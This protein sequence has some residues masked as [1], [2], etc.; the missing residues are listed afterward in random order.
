MLLSNECYSLIGVTSTNTCF[1]TQVYVCIDEVAVTDM[2]LLLLIF[3]NGIQIDNTWLPT[4]TFA[5]RQLYFLAH[6]SYHLHTSK[7]DV[8]ATTQNGIQINKAIID[9]MNYS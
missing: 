6:L 8:V 4:T 3:Y 9:S 7:D 2:L 5:T 1:P